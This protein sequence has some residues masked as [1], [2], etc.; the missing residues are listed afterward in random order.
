MLF[1]GL[2][3]EG[4]RSTGSDLM[5][6]FNSPCDGSSIQYTK[7][8]AKTNLTKSAV[9]TGELTK[10]LRR[11]S[12]CKLSNTKSNCSRRISTTCISVVYIHQRPV[13][14]RKACQ[15][16]SVT[17][18][19]QRWQPSNISLACMYCSPVGSTTGTMS[20]LRHRATSCH[21]H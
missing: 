17:G 11:R 16:T 7:H 8:Q 12:N 18:H 10:F 13:A 14:V 5:R 15:Q 4:R 6:N 1:Q 20:H 3:T 21:A 19:P 9:T 2:H